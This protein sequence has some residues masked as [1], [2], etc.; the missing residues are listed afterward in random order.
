LIFSKPADY[1]GR[2]ETTKDTKY[3]KDNTKGEEWVSVEKCLKNPE[4]TKK[5]LFCPPI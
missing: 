3:T 5:R 4:F 2:I 1:A